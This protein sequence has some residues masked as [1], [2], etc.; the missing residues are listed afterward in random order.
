MNLLLLNSSLLPLI[1][2]MVT[3]ATTPSLVDGGALLRGLGKAPKPTKK[4]PTTR[5]SRRP[6]VTIG[7]YSPL[8]QSSSHLLRPP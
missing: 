6:A 3:V 7:M 1:V 5:V 8:Y 2:V 4:T